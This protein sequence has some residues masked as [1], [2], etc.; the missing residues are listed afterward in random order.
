MSEKGGE[1]LPFRR[2]LSE[3]GD[4]ELISDWFERAQRCTPAAAGDLIADLA[5]RQDHS[6]ESIIHAAAAAAVAGAAAVLL[7]PH[8][9][10]LGA[11]ESIQAHNLLAWKFIEEFGGF[12]DGPKRMLQYRQMLYPRTRERFEKKIDRATSN[13]LIDQ[14]KEVLASGRELHPS[15]RMHLEGVAAGVPPFGYEVVDDEPGA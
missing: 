1:V 15:V 8:N 7:A 2:V 11:Y 6:M 3:T 12:D 10:K 5:E 13:W 4:A 14:A 9:R